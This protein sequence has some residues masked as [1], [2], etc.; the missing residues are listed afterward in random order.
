MEPPRR[1]DFRKPATAAIWLSPSA[2]VYAG[3]LL[4]VGLHRG[5]VACLGEAADATLTATTAAGHTTGPSGA[6]FVEA[7]TL[8]RIDGA[9]AR[10]LFLYLHPTDPLTHH[11]KSLLDA[12]PSTRELRT[13][14]ARVLSS[15]RSFDHPARKMDP[16]IQRA[17]LALDRGEDLELSVAQLAARANLSQSRFMHVFAACTGVPFR[18]YRLWARIRAATLSIARGAPLTTAALDAGFATPSHFSEA[19]RSMFGVAPSHLRAMNITST[20]DTNAAIEAALNA[21]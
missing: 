2:A 10:A 11:A 13:S 21:P 19:F 7:R 16:R 14:P 15:L 1:E 4:G 18:R 20:E 8:H 12:V 17:L 9:C 3:P 6:I 5:A